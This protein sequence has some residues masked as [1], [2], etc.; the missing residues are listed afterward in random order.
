MHMPFGPVTDKQSGAWVS[1][2]SVPAR[3]NEGKISRNKM[4]DRIR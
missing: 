2:L 4:S 3:A 1:A